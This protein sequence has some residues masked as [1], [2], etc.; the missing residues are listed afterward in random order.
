MKLGVVG[1]GQ[2]GGK[3]TDRLL[4]YDLDNDSNVVTNALAINSA[5]ADLMGLQN[6]PEQNTILI[7]QSEVKGHGAGTDP[8]MGKKITESDIDMLRGSVGEFKVAELDAFLVVAGL[9]GGTGSGGA[10]VIA[11]EIQKVYREPVYG[12]GIL[13]SQEEGGIYNRNA[14]QTLERFSKQVDNLLLWD[15]DAWRATGESI[16]SGY[17]EMNDKLVTRIGKL[18]SAGEITDD[19]GEVGE[20][21]VDS[22]EII[23][24]LKS[25]GL[26][27]IGYSETILEDTKQKGIL[28]KFGFGDSK[29]RSDKLDESINSSNRITSI[30]REA[31]LGK[32]TLPAA[33]SSAE[34]ALVVVTGPPEYINR[35]GLDNARSWLEDNLETREVRAGDYPIPNATELSAIVLLSGVTESNRIKQLQ[36]QAVEAQHNMDELREEGSNDIDNLIRNNEEMDELL[37]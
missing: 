20:T 4:E 6:I 24:T 26:S 22:S 21:V 15:N 31:T 36:R 9:G 28:S 13:P 5:K 30:V 35:K 14:A 37:D 34:K 33:V 27:S 29:S 1:F 17:S 8:E 2:A 19:H 12:L 3:I 18:F 32:L 25:S 7:G 10:P 16:E 23:N 11:R